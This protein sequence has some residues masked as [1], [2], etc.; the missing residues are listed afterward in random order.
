MGLRS[1]S[2]QQ[3]ALAGNSGSPGKEKGG[4]VINLT[5]S[6][7]ESSLTGWSDHKFLTGQILVDS[8]GPGL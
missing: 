1:D 6:V 7:T 5:S 8:E 3:Q 4:Y 2:A